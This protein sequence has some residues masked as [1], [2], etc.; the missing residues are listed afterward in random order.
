MKK[1]QKDKTKAYLTLPFIVEQLKEDCAMDEKKKHHFLF[2]IFKKDK[3]D[4][5]MSAN[6]A[7]N[8]LKYVKHVFIAKITKEK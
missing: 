8:L 1:S 4:N 6:K 3:E 7:E 5:P 2:Y